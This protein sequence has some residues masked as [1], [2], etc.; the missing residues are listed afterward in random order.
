VRTWGCDERWPLRGDTR[1][2]YE[3]DTDGAC[4]H[5]YV[6]RD[7]YANDVMLQSVVKAVRAAGGGAPV[8][9]EWAAPRWPAGVSGAVAGRAAMDAG[10]VANASGRARRHRRRALIP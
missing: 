5:T 3:A 8:A 2:P 6:R 10:H 7:S 1:S 9:G 4:R